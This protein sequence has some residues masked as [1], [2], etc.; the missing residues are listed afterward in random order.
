MSEDGV[1][2]ESESTVLSDTAAQQPDGISVSPGSYIQVLQSKIDA[3]DQTIKEADAVNTMLQAHILDLRSEIELRDNALAELKAQ[4][5]VAA[6]DDPVPINRAA[7]RAQKP[8]AR[9]DGSAR[10]PTKRR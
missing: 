6:A 4:N 1:T 9:K 7:R 10:Q 8:A 2:A 3:R 5:S